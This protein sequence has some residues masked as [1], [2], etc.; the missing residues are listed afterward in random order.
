MRCHA[1]TA[2]VHSMWRNRGAL[3]LSCP[4]QSLLPPIDYGPQRT[5]RE[6]EVGRTLVKDRQGRWMIRHGPGDYKVRCDPWVALACVSL[7]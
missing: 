3:A 6:L 1:C 2:A 4:Q 7:A 5:L